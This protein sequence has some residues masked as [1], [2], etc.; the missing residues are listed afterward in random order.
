MK[1]LG[2]NILIVQ[3]LSGS[4]TGQ[5]AFGISRYSRL[6]GNF[7]GSSI[8]ADGGCADPTFGALGIGYTFKGRAHC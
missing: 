3:L 8:V 6:Q 1:G 2:D 7:A 5:S 4:S